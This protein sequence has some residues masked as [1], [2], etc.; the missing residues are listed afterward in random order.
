MGLNGTIAPPFLTSA[1]YG[2]EWPASL[3]IRFILRG[4][5][6][7]THWIG[8]WVSPNVCLDTAEEKK[9]FFQCW[10]SKHCRLARTP[11]L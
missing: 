1:M 5:S 11:S 10:G 4:K 8:G 7:G 9:M 6:S 2:G 3:P